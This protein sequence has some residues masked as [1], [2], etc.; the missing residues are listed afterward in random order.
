[1][2]GHYVYDTR[3]RIDPPRGDR[4]RHEMLR[5]TCSWCGGLA[6]LVADAA[7]G[8]DWEPLGVHPDTCRCDNCTEDD[9]DRQRV[10]AWLSSGEE[11]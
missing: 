8:D 1:M 11:Q 4:C 5:G 3:V 10:K 2:N 6:D 9:N 7:W